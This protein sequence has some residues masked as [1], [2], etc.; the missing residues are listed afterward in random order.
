MSE[1]EEFQ[2][3]AAT[4]DQDLRLENEEA[5]PVAVATTSLLNKEKEVRLEMSATQQDDILQRGEIVLADCGKLVSSR[6]GRVVYTRPVSRGFRSYP[7]PIRIRAQH[8]K[9]SRSLN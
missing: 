2:D 8:Y 4:D 6:G 1:D 3:A 9:G 7:S 5:P